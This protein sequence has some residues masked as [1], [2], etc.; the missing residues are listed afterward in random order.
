MNLHHLLGT[1]RLWLTAAALVC[2]GATTSAQSLAV[3]AA[4]DLQGILPALV[5]RFEAQT[6]RAVRVT[7][8]SS[9]TFFSQIQNGAPFDVFFSADI[10]YP[11][12]LEAL[13]LAEPG[14]LYQYGTGKIVLWVPKGSRLDVGLGL[15]VLQTPGIR[16]IAI[17]NPIHA[18]YGRAAVAALRSAGLYDRVRAKLV[19]GEN[20][21]QAA[22][23]VQSGNAEVGIVAL[24]LALAPALSEAGVAGTIPPTSYPAIE[25]A[26]VVLKSSRIKKAALEFLRFLRQPD[27]LDLLRRFGFEPPPIGDGR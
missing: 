22:Q 27:A 10:E 18:P 21:S 7:F 16:H 12:R 13:S 2:G 20:V 4:A 23:F 25:Q 6:G 9:G 8:G 15:Q 5:S 19:L 11:K 14:T 17:A 26:A 1:S 3:A 24:S